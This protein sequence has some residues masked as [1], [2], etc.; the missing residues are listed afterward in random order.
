LRRQL[1]LAERDFLRPGGP[2]QKTANLLKLE[3]TDGRVCSPFVSGLGELIHIPPKGASTRRQGRRGTLGQLRLFADRD[4][5]DPHIIG[6]A[7]HQPHA[8]P[9]NGGD[10]DP[11]V[12]RD[13]NFLV[14]FPT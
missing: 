7:H 6:C 12:L 14:D 11:D 5:S 13:D 8:R 2:G 1:E 10:L 3:N 4:T 9:L